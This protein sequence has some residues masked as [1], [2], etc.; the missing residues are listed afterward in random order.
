MKQTPLPSVII[1]Y[2]LP[3]LLILGPA[4]PALA[5]RIQVIAYPSENE[6]IVEATVGNNNEPVLTGS[7][8]T[9]SKGT[10]GTILLQGQTD[11]QGRFKFPIPALEPNTDLLIT[12]NSGLGHLGSKTLTAEELG[13]QRSAETEK[14]T[15]VVQNTKKVSCSPED[16]RLADLV[17]EAVGREIEP[18]K[19]MLAKEM[20]SGP[21][22]RDIIGGIGWLVGIGGLLAALK[23]K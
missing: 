23:K 19:H 20:D 3:L 2:L 11:S 6:I 16:Q 15:S 5:H 21:S 22:M 9:V 14:T 10:K 7:E 18:L 12:V 8:V 13:P 1:H 4:L 17:A